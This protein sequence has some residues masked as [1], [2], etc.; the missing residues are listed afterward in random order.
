MRRGEHPRG[1]VHRLDLLDDE[2]LD[3]FRAAH[4]DASTNAMDGALSLEEGS[5]AR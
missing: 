4:P 1:A 5:S 2:A 3:R